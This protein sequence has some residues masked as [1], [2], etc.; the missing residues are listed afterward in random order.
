MGLCQSIQGRQ[1]EILFPPCLDRLIILVGDSGFLGEFLLSQSTSDSQRLQASEQ[2]LNRFT[3]HTGWR[4]AGGNSTLHLTIGSAEFAKQFHATFDSIRPIGRSLR[5][6]LGFQPLPSM[7]EFDCPHCGVSISAE[8]TD[9]G[10]IALCP[11][12]GEELLVPDQNQVE[13]NEANLIHS[14]PPVP[15]NLPPLP[16]STETAGSSESQSPH[17]PPKIAMAK[18]LLVAVGM[19]LLIKV[20]TSAFQTTGSR[21]RDVE[22]AFFR[23]QSEKAERI[24]GKLREEDGK[25]CRL[26]SGN[27]RGV[28]VEACRNCS[29]SGTNRTPSGYVI[30][31]SG[32]QGVGRV[33][34]PC[35]TCGGS[36]IYRSPY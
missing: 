5:Q 9:G 22:E 6:V 17:R 3:L 24:V 1:S 23:D 28:I 27:G 20:L 33:K 36:G 21:G 14:L 18:G 13:D 31:C 32:C 16:S 12:C 4:V 34:E 35:R 11:S 8:L 19:V 29:G 7:I 15:P 30:V 2:S 25:P 26:C 10:G